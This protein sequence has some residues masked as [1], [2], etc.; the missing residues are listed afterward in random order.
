MRALIKW[1]DVHLGLGSFVVVIVLRL[2][3]L[4]Y[5][6]QHMTA[7]ECVG[8]MVELIRIDQQALKTGQKKQL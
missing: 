4:E 6:G 8:K 3:I 5:F 2:Q 7:D 1:S